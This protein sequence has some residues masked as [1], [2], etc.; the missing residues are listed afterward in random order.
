MLGREGGLGGEEQQVQK[1]WDGAACRFVLAFPDLYEVGMSHL[2][3]RILYEILNREPRVACER[4]FCP[5]TNSWNLD[6]ISPSKF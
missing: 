6:G 4:V 5:D 2:G 3:L 1:D